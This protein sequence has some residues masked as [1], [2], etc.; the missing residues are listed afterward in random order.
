[1]SRL[2]ARIG[3]FLHANRK[4]HPCRQAPRF[5]AHIVSGY[6]Y[7]SVSSSSAISRRCAPHL[8]HTKMFG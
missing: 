4:A 8:G 1:M 5:T 3:G 7:Y 2:S 6:S